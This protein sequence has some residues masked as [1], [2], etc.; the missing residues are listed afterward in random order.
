MDSASGSQPA[1]FGQVCSIHE[2]AKFNAR[3]LRR[4]IA[5]RRGRRWLSD[6]IRLWRSMMQPWIALLRGINVGGRNAMPMAALTATFQSAG[7]GSVRTYIQSGNVV[8][9][10]PEKSR[11]K[12]SKRLGDAIEDQFGFR[13]SV[14]LLTEGEFRAA[15]ANNPFRSAVTEPKTLHF[16]FLDSVPKSP[17]MKGI[18]KLALPTERYKLVDAIFYL[19]TPDGF[20]RSKL[21][22]GAE[23]RLGEP[24]TARN[25]TTIQKL[26]EML[27]AEKPKSADGK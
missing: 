21:A 1:R 22:A 9:T 10:S 14:L 19:H 2:A 25:F 18:E 27:D 20:G 26:S 3:T 5:C 13:P 15:V 16:F 6:Q 11:Q 24:A 8:F 17:D 7:C 4:R 23:R 12:L